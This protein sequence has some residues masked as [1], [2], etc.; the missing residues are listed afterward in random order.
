MADILDADRARD[1]Q[2]NVRMGGVDF[3]DDMDSSPAS[4]STCVHVVHEVHVVRQ[5]LK[6]ERVAGPVPQAAPAKEKARPPSPRKT[7]QP[8]FPG[9]CLTAS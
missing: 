3:I 8:S 4:S 7:T 2:K 5:S 9:R 6:Q 1:L